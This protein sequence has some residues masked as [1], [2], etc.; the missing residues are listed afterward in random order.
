MSQEQI[1]FIE[2]IRLYKEEQNDRTAAQ[3]YFDDQLR[4]F[5]LV[6]PH[7]QNYDLNKV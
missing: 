2:E 7:Q 1:P 3:I 5:C 6:A 4:K